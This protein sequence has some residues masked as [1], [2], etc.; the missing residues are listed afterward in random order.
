MVHID[1]VFLS[2]IIQLD[3]YWLL[4]RASVTYVRSFL[5]YASP[6]WPPLKHL[7]NEIENVQRSLSTKRLP[8][9]SSLSIYAERLSKLKLSTL[10]RRRLIVDSV[11]W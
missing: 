10:E 11:V 9:F 4:K 7:I 5:E 8:G 3:L 1:H 6:V 2:A